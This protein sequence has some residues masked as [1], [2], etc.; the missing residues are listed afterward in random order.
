MF[1]AIRNNN[2]SKVKQ[3]L[4]PNT[5][6]KNIL[7]NTHLSYACLLGTY[8]IIQELLDFQI[9]WIDYSNN[10]KRE[11]CKI[12]YNIDTKNY[13]GNDSL[14]IVVSNNNFKITKLLLEYNANINTTNSLH[15]SPLIIAVT[16]KYYKIIDLLMTYNPNLEYVIDDKNIVNY[17][18]MYNNKKFIKKYNHRFTSNIINNNCLLYGLK[19][20]FDIIDI[21]L[22]NN[23]I[24]INCEN[25]LIKKKFYFGILLYIFGK[26]LHFEKY[27][28]KI[29]VN[30][31]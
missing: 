20:N 25:I 13:Y 3:L 7:G 8:D 12:T 31:L 10:K 2:L 1:K 5:G 18:I 24:R 9:S 17:A 26:K 6:E 11:I 14:L 27:L 16:C 30:F 15:L 21:L 29:I 19:Y 22:E 28:I 4:S 23:Y